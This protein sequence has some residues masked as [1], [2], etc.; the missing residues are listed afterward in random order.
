MDVHLCLLL[1]PERMVLQLKMNL[2]SPAQAVVFLAEVKDSDLADQ[3]SALL[4]CDPWLGNV[5]FGGC[6]FRLLPVTSGVS[7]ISAT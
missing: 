3:V 1:L 5:V 6:L 7:D 4:L 2:S